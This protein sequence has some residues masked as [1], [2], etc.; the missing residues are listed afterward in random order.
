MTGDEA[1][2]IGAAALVDPALNPVRHDVVELRQIEFGGGGKIEAV[3]VE[4][5]GGG[6]LAQILGAGDV[7]RHEVDA[8][9]PPLG[10]VAARIAAVTP[11]P[12]PSSHQ[13]NPSLRAGGSK[14]DKSATKSSQAGA[15]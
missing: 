8:A 5:G 1:A 9:E 15:M 12:Q 3:E 14:P 2:Q 13:A 6:T 7:I 10:C 4:I 11:W